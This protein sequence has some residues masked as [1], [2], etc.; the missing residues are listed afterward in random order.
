MNLME[1][2]LYK[3]QKVQNAAARL[4]LG[5]QK[6]DSAKEALEELHWLNIKSRIVFKILLLVYKMLT[7][8]CPMIVELKYKESDKASDLFMLETEVFKTKY[9][10]RL[11]AYNGPRLWNALSLG[12]R[13]QVNIDSFKGQLKTYLFSDYDELLK[14]ANMYIE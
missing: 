9:G 1:E 4:I 8:K 10:K 14:K 6:R 11:F 5:K 13:A 12:I 7:G 2:N 3:M